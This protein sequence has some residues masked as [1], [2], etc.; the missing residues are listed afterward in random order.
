MKASLAASRSSAATPCA[1]SSWSAL[2]SGHDQA[3]VVPLLPQHAIQQP[4]VGRCRNARQFVECRHGRDRTG[5]EGGPKRREIDLAQRPLGDIYTVVIQPSF[6]RAVGGEMLG[7]GC[8]RIGICQSCIALEAA[9]PRL[10]EQPR[11]QHVFASALDATAPACIAGDVHHRREGPVQTH[12]TGLHGRCARRA[13]C[14][15]WLEAGRF[16][17][18]H[19]EDGG[20]A[21]DH[22]GGEQQRNAQPALQ[23]CLLQ[24]LVPA[25]VGAIEDPG[26]P[27]G[28]GRSQLIVPIGRACKRVGDDR[29][30]ILLRRAEQAELASFFFHAHARDQCVDESRRAHRPGRQRPAGGN[31]REQA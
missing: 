25:H 20:I 4:H 14:Q 17:Q 24:L 11:Q 29:L 6:G 1:T 12:R 19:G 30:A 10:C 3:W 26:Q 22:I 23:R 28:P 13:P 2:K 16:G 27:P 31:A 9:H 15:V 7:T 8:H 18:W 21:M 5:S